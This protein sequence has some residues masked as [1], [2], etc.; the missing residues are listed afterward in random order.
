MTRHDW[1]PAP[2]QHRGDLT[3][4]FCT[5]EGRCLDD[6]CTRVAVVVC[7]RCREARCAKHKPRKR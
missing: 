5:V 3:P 2:K 6:G 1:K 4:W 7:K